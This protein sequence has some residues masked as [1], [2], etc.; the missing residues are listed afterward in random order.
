LVDRTGLMKAVLSVASW[1]MQMVA[2]MD[3]WL[4]NA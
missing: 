4:E 1:E 3:E 2:L